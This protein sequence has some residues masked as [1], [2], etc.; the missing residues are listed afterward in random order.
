M[1]K[2]NTSQKEIKENELVRWIKIVPQ[3][4]NNDNETKN[5]GITR[6]FL[7]NYFLEPNK[8]KHHITKLLATIITQRTKTKTHK[9]TKTCILW[10][11]ML[12]KKNWEQKTKNENH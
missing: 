3:K 11:V 9:T 10:C 4:N 1:I 12:L 8:T 5:N 6:F 2:P 7:N